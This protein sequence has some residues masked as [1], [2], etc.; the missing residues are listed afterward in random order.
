MLLLV[1]RVGSSFMSEETLRPSSEVL[2]SSSS[3]SGCTAFR[4]QLRRMWAA[5]D[6]ESAALSRTIGTAQVAMC[7]GYGGYVQAQS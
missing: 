5:T 4:L 2:L 6:K 1:K 3:L 7:Q